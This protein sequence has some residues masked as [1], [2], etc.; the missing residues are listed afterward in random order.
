MKKQTVF[1]SLLFVMLSATTAFAQQH[2]GRQFD[3]NETLLSTESHEYLATDYIRL[4][5]G[6]TFSATSRQSALF[7]ISGTGVDENQD[8]LVKVFPNPASG[9][10][11]FDLSHLPLDQESRLV[12]TDMIGR[13]SL[14]YIVPNGSEL[15]PIDVSALKSGLY[16]YQ[17]FNSE[18]EVT[19]G[20]V[21]LE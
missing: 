6:F 8:N 17:I 4:L 19:K 14:S 1:I 5:P 13:I 18:K 10:L 3:L 12:I 11:R 20:M 7:H 16:F 21:V 2:F 9:I 15:L